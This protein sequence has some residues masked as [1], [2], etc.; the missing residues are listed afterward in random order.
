VFVAGWAR[1][2]SSGLVGVARKDGENGAR[3][4]I[5]YLE[6]HPAQ[7]DPAAGMAALLGRLAAAGVQPVTLADV[8]RLEAAEAAEAQ[9]QGVEEFK[10]KSN[11][12]MLAAIT[13][14]EPAG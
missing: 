8:Q 11:A 5:Q 9:R 13:V 12:E 7:I 6:A 14:G 10:F 3:A 2:A 4:L 1:E